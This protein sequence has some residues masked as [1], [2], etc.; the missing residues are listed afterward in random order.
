MSQL[1]T[2]LNRITLAT[3]H[4][5]AMVR[6]YN[7]VFD[8]NLQPQP[9]LGAGFHQGVLSG[10]T[11]LLCPNDIAGVD[12]SSNRHQL[13]FTVN[14]IDEVLRR[15]QAAGGKVEGKIVQVGSERLAAV[16]DPDGNTIE[17][18]QTLG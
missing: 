18:N 13:R 17:F 8:A 4:M 12:A 16:R 3:T 11:L 6:F 10:L 1:E 2:S 5:N 9:E 7:L 15:T 14:D